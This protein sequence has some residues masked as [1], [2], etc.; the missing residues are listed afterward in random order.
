MGEVGFCGQT[1]LE[2]KFEICL[3]I[4]NV[5][6]EGGLAGP[7]GPNIDHLLEAPEEEGLFRHGEGGGGVHILGIGENCHVRHSESI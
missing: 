5:Q 4:G 1:K 6:G 7:P 3:P 2:A